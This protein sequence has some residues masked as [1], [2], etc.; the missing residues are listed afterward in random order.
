MNRWT[1][2]AL[3]ALSL[4]AVAQPQPPSRQPTEEE[5]LG[6]IAVLPAMQVPEMQAFYEANRDA[7][8]KALAG[9]LRSLADAGDKTAQFTYGTLLMTGHCVPQDLCAARKYR[10]QSRGG[11]ND[12]EKLYPVPPFLKKKYDDA[13]CRDAS[14]AKPRQ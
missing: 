7:G 12:W 8:G 4:D 2:A 9:K 14:S 11:A 6:L 1:C 3:V 10:E 13:E 5:C